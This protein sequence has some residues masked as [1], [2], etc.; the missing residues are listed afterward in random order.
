M[1]TAPVRFQHLGQRKMTQSVLVTTFGTTANS[2][3][4]E[5]SGVVYEPV[6]LRP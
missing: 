3:T 2:Y 4:L 5:S 1:Q 6:T